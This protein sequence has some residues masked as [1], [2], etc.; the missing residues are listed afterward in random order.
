MASV[1]PAAPAVAQDAP[2]LEAG[3]V[4][5]AGQVWSVRELGPE[6]RFT[7]LRFET[8]PGA[9]IVHGSISG[10]GR[11]DAGGASLT[12]D[13]GHIP[14]EEGAAR[15]SVLELKGSGARPSEGFETGYAQWRAARAGAFTMTIAEAIASVVGAVRA[16][17]LAGE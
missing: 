9:R 16:G 13:G 4:F 11:V 14:F 1:I 15:R 6:V 5:E 8:W 7:V 12:P 17:Q 3:P 2:V 10:Y